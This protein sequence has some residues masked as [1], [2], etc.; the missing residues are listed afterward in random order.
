VRTPQSAK[1]R[2]DVTRLLRRS[3]GQ[4]DHQQIAARITRQQQ[5]GGHAGDTMR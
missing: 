2:N 3:Q 1:A 5:I 4:H